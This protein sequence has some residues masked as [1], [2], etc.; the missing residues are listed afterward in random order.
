[1]LFSEVGLTYRAAWAGITLLP[2][3]DEF[4]FEV[5]RCF[6]YLAISLV[7]RLLELP[8]VL[9]YHYHPQISMD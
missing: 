2:F 6:Y 1:M 9:L 7:V 3:P 8:E 5:F 4:Y